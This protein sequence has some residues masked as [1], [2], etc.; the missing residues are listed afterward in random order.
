MMTSILKK[1][2]W[3][4]I[5]AIA[6]LI[7]KVFPDKLPFLE[8]IE[9]GRP[10]ISSDIPDPQSINQTP[11]ITIPKI[12]NFPQWIAEQLSILKDGVSLT[13]WKKDH[14]EEGVV[15]FGIGGNVGVLLNDTW[16][17]RT[18]LTVSLPDGKTAV[19]HAVFYPPVPPATFALPSENE[20]SKDYIDNNCTLG[21]IWIKLLE[22]DEAQGNA[23]A[24]Q[25]RDAIDQR[26][27]KGQADISLK[28]V[29]GKHLSTTGRWQN[30]N[31]VFIAAY[32]TFPTIATKSV[33]GV[34]FE[35]K[36]F[37]LGFLPNSG[38]FGDGERSYGT[39]YEINREDNVR[40]IR[41]AVETANISRKDGDALLSYFPTDGG[42]PKLQPDQA[43][44]LIALL[45]RWLSA[46]V[47]LNV[48]RKAAAL[49][50]AD[51]VLDQMQY[52]IGTSSLEKGGPARQSL[53]TH[54]AIFF[55]SELEQSY[56]YAHSW[57]ESARTIDA[58]G[59]MGDLAFRIMLD[60]GCSR[61]GK[62]S[63]EDVI[64]L[65]EDYLGKDHDIK[66]KAEVE[67]MVADAYRDIVAL[68]AGAG[69]YNENPDIYKEEAIGARQKAI[70]HYRNALPMLQSSTLTSEAWHEAWRL[71]VGLPPTDLRYHCVYD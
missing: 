13:Q 14:P 31:A 60:M 25:V 9:S 59:P 54:G 66:S 53:E 3:L 19:R 65:G 47:K 56:I 44:S 55:K 8:K 1:Y 17:A 15:S 11:A 40:R 41:Q 20:I 42:T 62:F 67:L 43:M 36:Y 4:I 37:A 71:I 33:S 10:A 69:A 23:L 6:V 12:E 7:F 28:R 5:L 18:E 29:D 32:N 24:R 52:Q 38:F 26:F 45:E 58:D 63:Y 16:C 22:Y 46:S 35:K 21:I 61:Y 48:T 30:G 51:Q 68:A 27:G 39:G 70:M 34:T 64:K 2:W 50:V 57:L 49:L